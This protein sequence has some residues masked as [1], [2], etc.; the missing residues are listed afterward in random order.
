MN[1]IFAATAASL[2]LVLSAP[3][4]ADDH[5]DGDTMVELTA[6]QQTMYDGWPEDRQMAYDGWPM[7]A[8]EYYWTLDADQMD[9]WWVLTDPQRVRIV[10]MTPEGRTQAWS[11]IMN[12][13]NGTASVPSP[14]ASATAQATTATTP[15]AT[16]AAATG[17]IRFV[18]GEKAQLPKKAA[19]TGDLPVCTAGQQDGCINSWEKNKTGTR[20]LNY[21]PGKPASEM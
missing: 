2:A 6:A 1:K 5:M 3:A 7:E 8:Q 16:N 11:S 18:S 12:P 19:V 10:G 15:A 13:I 17:N 4:M 9:G 14:N 21:W 20:P